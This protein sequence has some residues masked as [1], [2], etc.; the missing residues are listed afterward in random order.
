MWR[1]RNSLSQ[2][3]QLATSSSSKF[4]S[5]LNLQPNSLRLL[6]ISD[7]DHGYGLFSRSTSTAAGPS[8]G[9]G[10]LGITGLDRVRA[11]GSTADIVD[12]TTLGAMEV[13]D[14]ARHY[15]RCYW[16]L[17]KA[18]LRFICDCETDVDFKMCIAPGL[19]VVHKKPI[20]LKMLYWRKSKLRHS[21][22]FKPTQ[23][24]TRRIEE[25]FKDVPSVA[26]TLMETLL[27]IDPSQ[28]QTA[29]S[30]LKSEGGEKFK[31]HK[32]ETEPSNWLSG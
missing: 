29:S 11:I 5:H 10:K 17:S 19:L 24:Y 9:L 6:Q 18:K 12:A 32:I 13:V 31:I 30:A 20:L 4:N 28:R 16:E 22:V 25:T 27:A 26:I 2:F 1:R 14:M 23:P 7:V 3:T 8:F 21:A 15:G